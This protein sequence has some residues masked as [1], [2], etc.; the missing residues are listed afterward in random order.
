MTESASQGAGDWIP[1][2]SDANI[3]VFITNCFPVTWTDKGKLHRWRKPWQKENHGKRESKRQ[4][5]SYEINGLANLSSNLP[6]YTLFSRER[7]RPQNLMQLKTQTNIPTDFSIISHQ[8]SQSIESNFT[9]YYSL[10]LVAHEMAQSI[11]QWPLVLA[12][13]LFNTDSWAL[14]LESLTQ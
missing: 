9:C 10:L 5:E 4:E 11:E 3:R 12:S 14:S 7:N 13:T 8:K 6:F 2:V 1:G